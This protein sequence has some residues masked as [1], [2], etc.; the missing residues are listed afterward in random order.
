MLQTVKVLLSRTFLLSRCLTWIW[1]RCLPKISLDKNSRLQTPQQKKSNIDSLFLSL[2]LSDLVFQLCLVSMLIIGDKSP[3]LL[4]IILFNFFIPELHP[5][6]TIQCPSTRERKCFPTSPGDDHMRHVVSKCIPGQEYRLSPEP[7]LV[8]QS[9]LAT[10]YVVQRNDH[11]AYQLLLRS[12][13]HAMFV[14]EGPRRL[15]SPF[16]FSHKTSSSL[17]TH[18][19]TFYLLQLYR[20]SPTRHQNIPMIQWNR[21]CLPIS[22]NYSSDSPW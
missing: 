17:M 22:L 6:L 20:Q 12:L 4:S 19:Q 13:L 8:V 11:I 10:R 1:S 15:C 2:S 18:D 5:R 16:S 3:P 14:R 9:R 7:S 21:C